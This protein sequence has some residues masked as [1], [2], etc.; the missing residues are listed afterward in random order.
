MAES[1]SSFQGK[2]P[3]IDVNLFVNALTQGIAAGNAQDTTV[4]SIF[5]GISGGIKSGIQNYQ[6]IQ[7]GRLTEARA[8]LEG[9]PYYQV[10]DT[11]IS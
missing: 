7:A 11:L 3:N 10:V 1:Y 2:E 9:D 6:G 4:G 5:K 8:D